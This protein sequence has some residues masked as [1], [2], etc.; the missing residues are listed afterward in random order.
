M[1]AL[2]ASREDWLVFARRLAVFTIVYN[3]AEGLVSMGF[4]LA[5]D[6]IALFGFGADSFIEVGSALM[7]LW[8]LRE[9]S[10]CASAR[11][12][13]ERKATLGIGI[14][15]LLL[16]VGT[17]L[18]SML[19]L[20]TRR[21]PETTLPGLLISLVSL[22][23]MFG[24]WRAKLRAAKVLDSRT[25]EGDAACSLACI[26][27]SS[28]LFLGSLG[29]LLWPA[30]WWADAVVALAIAALIAREGLSG[31]RAALNPG[32]SGGCGCH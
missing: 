26:Q 3:L 25:L 14:L 9:E 24:L 5:D 2:G 27:L 13:R 1:P 4:G 20:V 7:V 18:A 8:R 10:G 19:Q 17:G 15:F 16:A 23:F 21:H 12:K 32:F 22:L 6:S 28:V 11:L 31:I 29:F 30:L